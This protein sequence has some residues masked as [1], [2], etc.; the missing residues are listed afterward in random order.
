MCFVF[1]KTCGGVTC[2]YTLCPRVWPHSLLSLQ[3]CTHLNPVTGRWV[4]SSFHLTQRPDCHWHPL[5]TEEGTSPM[6]LYT[7]KAKTPRILSPISH[8]QQGYTHVYQSQHD[9]TAIGSVI[10]IISLSSSL[11]SPRMLITCTREIV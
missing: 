7:I 5:P 4:W 2:I 6:F 3:L 9:W 8:M 10:I 1:V 11:L